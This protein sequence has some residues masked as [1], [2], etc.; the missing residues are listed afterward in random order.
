[1]AA[2]PLR[3]TPTPTRA[4]RPRPEARTASHLRV[5]PAR[6]R[7]AGLVFAAAIGLA[8]LM[9]GAAM[10]NTSLAE[11]QLRVDDLEQRVDEA[12]SRFEMLR[13]Q[14]AELR[15]PG[16][17]AQEGAALGMF[18]ASSSGFIRVDPQTYAE[19]LAS[20]GSLDEADRIVERAQPLDQFRTVK[21]AARG[22]P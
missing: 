20:T 13:G 22:S 14:R 15:S 17:L 6:R 18:P 3:S 16:R 1:M 8:A 5:V 19:V 7:T 2:L 11:R 12:N 21:Q 10:L 9:L 4:R